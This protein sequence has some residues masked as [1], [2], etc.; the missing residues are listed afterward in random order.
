[1][2]RSS[3]C[4]LIPAVLALGAGGLAAQRS[5]EG[6]VQYRMTGQGG[7]PMEPV[8]YVKGGK[9]RLEMNT[10]GQMGVMLIDLESG[11]MTALMPAQ[12]MYLTMNVGAMAQGLSAEHPHDEA[13][14]KIEPTGQKETIAGIA[15]EHYRITGSEDEAQADVCLAK[16]MGTFM[17]VS[18]P[19]AGGPMSGMGRMPGMGA[20]PPGAAELAKQFKDGAFLLKMD[21]KKSGK[22]EMSMVATR[23]ERKSLDASLFAPPSDYR[24]MKM[25]GR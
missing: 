24:E 1:M 5:F 16:G 4:L 21:L 20:M 25:P 3:T 10:R 13:N 14:V 8:Y 23:V 17:G 6:V 11:A 18:A 15:C 7:Q 19:A 9:T 12:K 2:L 22:T